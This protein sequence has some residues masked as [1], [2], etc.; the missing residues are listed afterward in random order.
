MSLYTGTAM[1]VLLKD[2]DNLLEELVP[3]IEDLSFVV[4]WVVAMLAVDYDAI[5]GQLVTTSACQWLQQSSC[6]Q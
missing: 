1:A 5:D 4:A 3:R 2:L 6:K